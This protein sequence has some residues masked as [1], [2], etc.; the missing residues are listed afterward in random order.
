MSYQSIRP[1][2]ELNV[3]GL[4]LGRTQFVIRAAVSYRAQL[5]GIE[6]ERITHKA[7]MEA[8]F[9]IFGEWE[10]ANRIGV[11]SVRIRV[12]GDDQLESFFA[13]WPHI[14]APRSDFEAEVLAAGRAGTDP[15][16][17]IPEA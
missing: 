16:S 8:L 7:Q 3:D 14:L 11:R 15:G 1:E 17:L 2:Y 13:R 10:R 4:V 12:V 6:R 9:A 5:A